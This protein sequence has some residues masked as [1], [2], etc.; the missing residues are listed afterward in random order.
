MEIKGETYRVT[1]DPATTTVAFHGSLRLRD[2]GDYDPINLL[3]DDVIVASPGVVTLDMRD[4]RFLNSLATYLLLGFVIKVR[5]QA[6]SQL[7]VRGAA[8]SFWQQRSFANL[9]KLMPGL[10]LEWA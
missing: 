2:V 4:L 3:L 6:A 8:G 1:F 5:E 10:Q 7:V 9:V